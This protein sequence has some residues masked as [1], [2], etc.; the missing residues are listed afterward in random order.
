MNGGGAPALSLVQESA[1]VASLE[2]S[3]ANFP[4]VNTHWRHQRHSSTSSEALTHAKSHTQASGASAT[5]NDN[6][7]SEGT[8]TSPEIT[9]LASAAASA[10]SVAAGAE[11][12]FANVPAIPYACISTAASGEAPSDCSPKGA[13]VSMATQ[14]TPT[15]TERTPLTLSDDA[16]APQRAPDTHELHVISCGN[17]EAECASQRTNGRSPQPAHAVGTA[18][19]EPAQLKGPMTNNSAKHVIRGPLPLTEMSPEVSMLRRR[20][21]SVNYGI[22][23]VDVD[24][25]QHLV[26]WAAEFE[27]TA[28]AAAERGAARAAQWAV[29]HRRAVLE[30][31]RPASLQLALLAT[32]D[33]RRPAVSTESHT[34]E[35]TEVSERL[36]LS[37]SKSYAA[38][39]APKPVGEPVVRGGRIKGARM[40]HGKPGTFNAQ[41]GAETTRALPLAAELQVPYNPD[42]PS[43]YARQVQSMVRS[44]KASVEHSSHNP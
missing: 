35:G 2:L 37:N 22:A 29:A 7:M 41:K 16:A 19:G 31:V 18:C 6:I 40:A 14:S 1:A 30:R 32:L 27:R 44:F 8:C 11:G 21:F 20:R 15:G 43:P 9:M 10:A 26:S 36:A 42:A 17:S 5:K 38:L 34:Q 39:Q 28:Q 4:S 24:V 23:A 13:S 12:T 3:M 33:R 25:E